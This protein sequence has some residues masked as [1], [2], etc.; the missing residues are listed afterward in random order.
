MFSSNK[1]IES[2]SQLIEE[3]KHYIGLQKEF[4]KLDVVEKIVLLLSAMI[5]GAILL[6]LG[7]MVLF[8][9]SFTVAFFLSNYAGLGQTGGFAIITLFC[10]FIFFLVYK[11]RKKWIEKPLTR[12]LANLLL[13]ENH[14]EK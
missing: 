1:N 10:S 5:L 12:F 9:L 13:N 8:Y 2:I 14:N 6:I 7:A 11:F 3:I 4:V